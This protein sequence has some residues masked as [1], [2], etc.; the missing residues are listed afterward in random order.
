MK[1]VWCDVD[2]GELR[3]R[4]FDALGIFVLIEFGADRE[5][6][7]GR[8]CG[9]EL[10][11][12]AIAAQGLAPPVDGDE[13]EE[14][15]LDFIPFAGSGRQMTNRDRYPELIGK[16]LKLDLPET[17]AVAVTATAVGG[18]HESLGTGIPLLSHCLP[19][20]ADRMNGKAGGVVIGTDADP[21]EIVGDVVDAIGHGTG[22]LGVDEVVDIDRFG[23]ALWPPFPVD[24]RWTWKA[25]TSSRP[26]R[27][28]ERPK[29]RQN[30]A[31]A[32]T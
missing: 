24:T 6:R 3:V 1:V 27:S 12:G 8:G 18:D 19:P 14:A 26:S 15:V 30:F 25:R 5:P 11:D 7:I 23:L 29:W 22:E 9:D 13:R 17:N 10:D 16:L 20:A 21:A 32:W 28:G 2:F 31:T 4:D